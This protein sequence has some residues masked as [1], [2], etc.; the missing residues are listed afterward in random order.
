MYRHLDPGKLQQTIALFRGRV[1]GVFPGS[2]LAEV[3]AEVEAAT[4]HCIS[5][6]RALALPDWKLR[7]W[8]GLA[9]LLVAIVPLE[10]Y[11]FSGVRARQ[12]ESLSE[13]VQVSDAAF[14]MLVLLGGAILF[15]VT[16][17][18]RIK[19][20]RALKALHELRSLAHVIDM[21]QLCKDPGMKLVALDGPRKREREPA[22]HSDAELWLYLSF[23]TDLLAVVGKGA[24]LFGDGQSDRVI[25]DTVNELEMLS[26]SLSRKIW[27][28]LSLVNGASREVVAGA[29]SDD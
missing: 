3:A 21:H 9:A 19:R 25:L 10:V 4:A 24:A 16:L 23:C 26:T 22:I 2:G 27:Q 29:L 14:N 8:A 17:E 7:C 20:R 15:L 11:F 1:A 28:K 13:F 5:E 6:V 18:E 12:F